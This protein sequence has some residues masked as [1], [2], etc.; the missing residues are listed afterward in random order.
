MARQIAPFLVFRFCTTMMTSFLKRLASTC[1]SY[2]R[3]MQSTTRKFWKAVLVALQWYHNAKSELW[4][5]DVDNPGPS[6]LRQ[7]QPSTES[8]PR[9]YL[10]PTSVGQ[11]SRP[12]VQSK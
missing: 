9:T 3:G 5:D 10:D 2:H 4:G 1:S 7:G 11:L 8:R 6:Q 12:I